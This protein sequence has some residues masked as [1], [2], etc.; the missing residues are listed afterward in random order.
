MVKHYSQE[1]YN[2]KKTHTIRNEKLYSNW[3]QMQFKFYS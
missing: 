2:I 1:I 3:M